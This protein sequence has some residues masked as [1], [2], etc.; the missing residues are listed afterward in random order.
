MST[1]LL[2][3]PAGD[4]LGLLRLGPCGTRPPIAY[5]HRRDPEPEGWGPWVTYTIGHLAVATEAAREA[6]GPVA[7]YAEQLL[8][9]TSDD[10]Q[11]APWLTAGELRRARAALA[12]VKE[13]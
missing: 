3:V 4:P 8:D 1:I 9:A 6:L 12:P 7:A 5:R 10:R 2:V 11:Y 13:D